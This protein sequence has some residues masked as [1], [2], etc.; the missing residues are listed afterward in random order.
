MELDKKIIAHLLAT[1]KSQIKAQGGSADEYLQVVGDD[2]LVI[3]GAPRFLC[4]RLGLRHNVVYAMILSPDG[5]VLLQTRGEPGRSRLDVAVGGH[6]REEEASL[7]IALSREMQEELGFRP[8]VNRL[9]LASVFNQDGGWVPEKPLE[10]NCERRSLYVYQLNSHEFTQL[11][12]LFEQRTEK[13][14]VRRVDWFTD[15]QVITACDEGRAADGLKGSIAHY[16]AWKLQIQRSH[17]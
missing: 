8:E 4:H 2:G 11:G 13:A 14:A 6:V 10:L 7:D 12:R 15:Q 9:I 16:L 1:T 5:S 3:G 17:Q